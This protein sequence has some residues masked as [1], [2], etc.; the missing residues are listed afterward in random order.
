MI[1]EPSSYN[2]EILLS[3]NST[4]IQQVKELGGGKKWE[5]FSHGAYILVE[6]TKYVTK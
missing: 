2:L 3:F 5:T 4:K 1:S 6:C